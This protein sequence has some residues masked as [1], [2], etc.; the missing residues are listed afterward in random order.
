[1]QRAFACIPYLTLIINQKVNKTNAHKILEYTRILKL[2]KQK[3]TGNLPIFHKSSKELSIEKIKER[4]QKIKKY[5]K[6]KLI[7]KS[8]VSTF[9]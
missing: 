7:R 6:G 2:A 9:D 5:G 3:A 4:H 8:A 1:M